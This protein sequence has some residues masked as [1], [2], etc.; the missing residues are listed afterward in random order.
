MH[1]ETSMM[2]EKENREICSLNENE[3]EKVHARMVQ[4]Q[5]EKKEGQIE[6]TG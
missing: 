3:T 6:L 2:S 5:E 4:S 1:D